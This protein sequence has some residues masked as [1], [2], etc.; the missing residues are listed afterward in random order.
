MKLAKK[1]RRQSFLES[2]LHVQSKKAQIS[3][4]RV[5]AN[6]P[7]DSAMLEPCR[8]RLPA[9]REGIRR[10]RYPIG[11]NAQVPANLGISTDFCSEPYFQ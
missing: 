1:K 10:R 6:S 5:L 2:V 4:L 9:N 8:F 7:G 3:P 11:S